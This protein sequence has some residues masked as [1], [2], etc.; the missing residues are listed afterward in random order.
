MEE[1]THQEPLPA[2]KAQDNYKQNSEM[3][4]KQSEDK[5]EN[6]AQVFFEKHSVFNVGLYPKD[7]SPSQEYI[8]LAS[9]KAEK[10]KYDEYIQR[11]CFVYEAIQTKY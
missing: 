10:P 7:Q 9:A 4:E 2:E 8:K 3:N 11:K 6:T 5:I 1:I